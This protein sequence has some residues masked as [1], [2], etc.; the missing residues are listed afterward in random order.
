MIKR[1]FIAEVLAI[2]LLSQGFAAE[3]EL[4]QVSGSLCT[5]LDWVSRTKESVERVSSST[6]NVSA[7]IEG[8]GVD[9]PHFRDQLITCVNEASKQIGLDIIADAPYAAGDLLKLY[10]ERCIQQ[11]PGLEI[12][13]VKVIKKQECP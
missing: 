10:I 3:I 13:V 6:I 12:Y 9:D 8:E 2:A 1:F 11:Q 7:V 4:G 5:Q